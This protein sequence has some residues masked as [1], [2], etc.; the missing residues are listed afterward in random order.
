MPANEFAEICNNLLGHPQYKTK[1]KSN[2]ML[3]EMYK[4][5]KFLTSKLT[6][7][8]PFV[9][10]QQLCERRLHISEMKIVP[11]NLYTCV[12]HV[13]KGRIRR[14]Y[15]IMAGPDETSLIIIEPV[16]YGGDQYLVPVELVE[17][18]TLKYI[19]NIERLF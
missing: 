15:Q 10:I 1:C 5:P 14:K 17:N 9:T 3:N 11:V 16:I 13:L 8:N 19:M 6:I 2:E 18:L 4:K 12:N 7:I